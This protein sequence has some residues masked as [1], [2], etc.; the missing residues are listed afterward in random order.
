MPGDI[1][2]LNVVF[3]IGNK[4]VPLD[5]KDLVRLYFTED[6]FD[7]SMVGKLVFVDRYGLK[8]FVLTGDEK[9]TIIWG[10]NND[11]IEKT[12]RIYSLN[13]TKNTTATPQASISTLTLLFCEDFFINLNFK[14]YSKSWN[15]M[16][17]TDII[18]D[19]IIK[20]VEENEWKVWDDGR[21]KLKIFNMPYWTPAQ[22]I[23][24]LL[25]RC[26]SLKSNTAGYIMYSNINGKYFLTLDTLFSSTKVEDDKYVLESSNE[27][28]LNKILSWK[29]E[30]P[31][32]SAYKNICGGISGGYNPLKKELLDPRYNYSQMVKNVTTLGN[33]TLFA[34]I[35]N[36]TNV[37]I[38]G[39]DD[40]NI[41]I[42]IQ[43]DNFI[44]SYS[45]Q[46]LLHIIV[47]GYHKRTIGTM[48]EIQWPSANSK[49]VYS[50]LQSGKYLVKTVVNHFSPMSN[51]LYQQRLI[52]IKNGYEENKEYYLSSNKTNISQT[53]A[54]GT[55]VGYRQ[56]AITISEY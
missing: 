22:T 19:I 41:I 12:F 54:I 34:K 36:M 3:K 14:K 8:E 50:K 48:I 37:D 4:D 24:W 32:K 47:P 28:Y 33:A 25:K 15:N 31:D 7:F 53:N 44:K 30:G 21:E 11:Y 43:Y 10:L 18:K 9:I 1:T 52:L 16:L 40:K 51:P 6:L 20:M 46:N 27:Y 49:E 26:S 5:N 42:N 39:D 56:P 17:I 55:T 38:T 35:D 2:L 29:H 23:K 13:Q 45:L